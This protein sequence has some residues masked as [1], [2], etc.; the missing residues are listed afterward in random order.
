MLSTRRHRLVDGE[1]RVVDDYF[2]R[3][4]RHDGPF[5]FEWEKGRVIDGDFSK[6]SLMETLTQ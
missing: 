3:P 5:S 6:A 2:F 1:R 4:E